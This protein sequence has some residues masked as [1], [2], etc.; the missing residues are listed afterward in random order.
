MPFILPE[1]IRA[2]QQISFGKAP[3]FDA[4]PPEVCK[5]S[6]PRL[7]VEFKTLFQEMWHQGQA[8]QD[9]KNETIVHLYKRKENRQLCDNHRGISLLKIA[10]E[11]FTRILIDRL[12]G[13][14]EQVLV[15]ESQCG[16]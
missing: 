15:P 13:H 8:P 10:G 4:I 9:F 7:M 1:S 6:S 11:L 16:F 2:V 3:G 14:L 5:H 12:I